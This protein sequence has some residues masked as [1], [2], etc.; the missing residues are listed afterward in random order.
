MNCILEDQLPPVITRKM[1]WRKM[2]KNQVMQHLMEVISRGECR[3]A[4][5]RFKGV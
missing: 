3:P 4:L 1:L 5:Q 2:L